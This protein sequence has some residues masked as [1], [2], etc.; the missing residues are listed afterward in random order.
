MLPCTTTLFSSGVPLMRLFE[1]NFDRSERMTM[2]ENRPLASTI[3]VPL[4]LGPY[5]RVWFAPSPEVNEISVH[6]P[7]K[8][9]LS[10]FPGCPTVALVIDAIPNAVIATK[11]RMLAQFMGRLPR[12]RADV[13]AHSH[14]IEKD[15][16]VGPR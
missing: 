8:R 7:T 6:V 5:G 1:A 16:A 13:R 4:G 10:L 12:V 3:I 14:S 2:I 15:R 9:S 11:R